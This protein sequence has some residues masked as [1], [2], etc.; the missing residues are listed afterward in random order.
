[1]INI[2]QV[3]RIAHETNKAF[4]DSIG[5]TSQKHWDDAEQWQRDSAI[6]G[7]QY[8]LDNPN[9]PASAQHDSWCTDKWANGWSYA[10]V[11]DPI[12]K[13]H[14]CLVPYNQLPV[15]Q[16]LKDHLFKAVVKAFSD[17]MDE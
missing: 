5:D 16:R 12:N 10:V 2:E 15:E 11:K 9:S 6:K 17:C 8:A 7:V 4:C 14:P 1:M 3:A 13:T